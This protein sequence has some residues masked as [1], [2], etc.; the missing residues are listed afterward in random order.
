MKLV[1]TDSNL[2]WFMNIKRFDMI[3]SR[4]MTSTFNFNNKKKTAAKMEQTASCFR[5]A[6]PP[7]DFRAVCLV[8]AIFEEVV[9]EE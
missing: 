6:L 1:K 9:S 3:Q 4:I 2:K 8:L 5:G 7:V